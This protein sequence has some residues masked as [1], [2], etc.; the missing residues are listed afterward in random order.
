[1]LTATPHGPAA[2]SAQHDAALRAVVAAHGQTLRRQWFLAFCMQGAI[3]AAAWPLVMVAGDHLLPGGWP[4]AIL[5]GSLL[6]WAGAIILAVGTAL[7]RTCR[8]RWNPV[9][10]AQSLERSADI[11]HNSLVNAVLL[12]ADER[13][14]YAIEP[15]LLQAARD[16]VNHDLPGR[17]TWGFTG[18]S[19]VLATLVAAAWTLYL[20]LAPKP[21][22]P[23]LARF[24]GAEVAAPTA[25]RIEWLRPTPADGPHVGEPLELAFAVR[26]QPVTAVE[27]DLLDPEGSVL[28]TRRATEPADDGTWSF[29]LA[30]VEVQGDVHFRCRAGDAAL[31]GTVRVHPQPDLVALEMTVTPPA[32]T[33]WPA[34]QPDTRSFTAL[35][36]STVRLRLTANTPLASAIVRMRGADG[37]TRTRMRVEVEDS[38]LAEATLFLRASSDYTIEFRDT[39]D[40][41]GYTAEQRIHV[42]ADLPPAIAVVAPTAEQIPAG[43][44]DVSTFPEIT[45]TASD[46][47]GAAVHLVLERDGQRTRIAVTSELASRVRGV[48][49]V[50][51]LPLPE[52]GVARA[53]FEA[54]DNRHLPDGRPAPQTTATDVYELVRSGAIEPA[55]TQP[56]DPGGAAAEPAVDSDDAGPDGPESVEDGDGSDAGTGQDPVGTGAQP[57]RTDD[58][59]Q[60]SSGGEPDEPTGEDS[61]PEDKG[62]ATEPPNPAPESGNEQGDGAGAAGA[63]PDF[64]A[65]LDEFVQEHGNEAEDASRAHQPDDQRPATPGPTEL[66]QPNGPAEPAERDATPVSA[67]APTTN[68]TPSDPSKESSAAA[69]PG[70]VPSPDVP[71]PASPAPSPQPN[72][73]PD[74]A[75]TNPGP[76]SPPETPP[77]E[78][79]HPAP[80]TASEDGTPTSA[81]GGGATE[82]RPDG[83]NTPAPPDTTP[84]TPPPDNLAPPAEREPTASDTPDT[85]RAAVLELLDR[86]DRGDPPTT[87]QLI[88]AGWSAERAAAFLRRLER[89]HV[90]AIQA[91]EANVARHLRHTTELGTEA[92][93]AGRGV[94]ADLSRAVAP[95]E[96]DIPVERTR[97]AEAN[98]PPEY[99]ELLEAY[100]RALRSAVPPTTSSS[101]T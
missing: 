78:G 3:L 86:M 57:E 70:Q 43:V 64:D 81:G 2:V 39:W 41:V 55:A 74:D 51:D 61:P 98:L 14:T 66:P 50:A 53:W 13:V 6:L 44:I 46:D 56:G 93:Q 59:K 63:E 42:V 35:A 31:A 20:L 22:A 89:L 87:D 38:A 23:S 10:L 94:H 49:R 30:P 85:G 60:A 72:P 69:T 21:A 62:D 45:V 84:P 1:M 96:G 40:Y 18:R 26:G 71:E 36:G 73:V 33:G 16:L 27:L 28:R 80:G 90:L 95:A 77:G 17:S 12:R 7:L 29:V 9:F 101:P 19:A 5:R 58:S 91:R 37:E 15:A 79:S 67:P 99:E 100:Y 52:D 65:A 34:A 47:V 97:P 4:H 76:V 32:Y 68:E 54:V 75:T 25:T 48:V 24:F 88:A 82:P 8:W 11:R 83:T 92:R